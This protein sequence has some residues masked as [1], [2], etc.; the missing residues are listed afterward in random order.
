MP[1]RMA[2]KVGEHATLPY[3]EG[4]ACAQVLIVGDQGGASAR[5]VFTGFGVGFVFNVLG[6]IGRLW[7]EV[8]SWSFDRFYRGGSLAFETNPA[9]GS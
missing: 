9:R 1:Q 7:S 6:Q 4:T 8:A 5:T 3:P 2:G